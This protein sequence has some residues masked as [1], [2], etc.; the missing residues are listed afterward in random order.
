MKKYR[1]RILIAATIFILLSSQVSADRKGEGG[2]VL[3]DTPVYARPGALETMTSLKKG[4]PVAAIRNEGLGLLLGNAQYVF[5][6]KEGRVQVFYFPSEDPTRGKFYSGW[7]DPAK[8]KKFFYDCSCGRKEGDCDPIVTRGLRFSFMWNSCFTQ[9]W[10]ERRAEMEA[11]SGEAQS[12]SRESVEERIRKLDELLA[13]G[14][15][16]KDE[17]DKKRAEILNSL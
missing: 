12:A 16:S 2:I 10:E 15:I 13:K 14:L 6:E 1:S 8:V 9:A 11:K 7:I 3:E 4:Q 17:Y 5:D